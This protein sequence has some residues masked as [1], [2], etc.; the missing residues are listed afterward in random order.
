MQPNYKKLS[1]YLRASEDDYDLML[2]DH[3]IDPSKVKDKLKGGLA[4]KKNP[5]D[6]PLDQLEKGLKVEK[7]HTDDPYTA[8]EISMDHLE[9]DPKYYTK[10]NKME[11]P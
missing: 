9:E 7:E 4:D 10:L 6:F 3:G 5:T 8:L 1:R 11:N 2:R